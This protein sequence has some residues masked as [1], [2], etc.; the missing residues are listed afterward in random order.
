M[1]VT[2]P[3]REDAISQH[4][5]KVWMPQPLYVQLF[6]W[7]LQDWSSSL[8]PSFSPFRDNICCQD[9][10]PSVECMRCIFI[11]F[12]FNPKP[13][14]SRLVCVLGY[15]YFSRLRMLHSCGHLAW[16]R[17]VRPADIAGQCCS[18]NCAF[19][20]TF[21]ISLESGVADCVQDTK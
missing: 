16:T 13:L 21:H 3:C 9:P 19:A 1:E 10:L 18:R 12:L 7:A 2:D 8:L 17:S 11:V 14:A 20:I 4:V 15:K 6:R 5:A